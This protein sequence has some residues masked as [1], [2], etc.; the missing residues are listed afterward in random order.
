MAQ[1]SIGYSFS[2][3]SICSA[4]VIETLKKLLKVCVSLNFHNKE[5]LINNLNCFNCNL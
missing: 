1:P 4:F 2:F 3:F 5:T